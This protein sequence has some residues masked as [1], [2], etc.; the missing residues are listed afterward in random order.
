MK[1]YRTKSGKVEEKLPGVNVTVSKSEKAQIAMAGG[2]DTIS[3]V[4][5]IL[6][7]PGKKN[8]LKGQGAKH[9]VSYEHDDM[10]TVGQQVGPSDDYGWAGEL[11]TGGQPPFSPPSPSEGGGG[12]TPAPG[13]GGR[14]PPGIRGAGEMTNKELL[15]AVKT[16]ADV[17]GGGFVAQAKSIALEQE[18]YRR[19]DELF[20][21]FSPSPSPLV[22]TRFPKQ[23]KQDLRL[24]AE[25][26]KIS[27]EPAPPELGKPTLKPDK[28]SRTQDLK[29]AV[30][31]Y[32]GLLKGAS[33]ISSIYRAIPV[34]GP[35]AFPIYFGAHILGAMADKPHP[36]ARLTLGKYETPEQ[37]ISRQ[38]VA[39]EKV[40]AEEKEAARPTK[41]DPKTPPPELPPDPGA[42]PDTQKPIKRKKIPLITDPNK[43]TLLASGPTRQQLRRQ[44]GGFRRYT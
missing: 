34:I 25:A 15:G 35:W 2:A 22:D 30:D 13:G 38:K 32:T 24:P 41:M 12:P 37:L 26:I 27:K 36:P 6:G 7:T 3:D 44:R 28:S 9:F 18:A 17:R 16:K 14:L 43:V 5:A 10:D 8:N 39:D 1:K 21:D 4:Q 11:D 19:G 40:A 20:E 23:T 29:K 31:P 33:T 42:D